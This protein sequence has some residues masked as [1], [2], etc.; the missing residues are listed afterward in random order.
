MLTEPKLVHREKL[1]FVAIQAKVRREDIPV[2]LPQ[3]IPEIINW[4]VDN[5]ILSYGRPFFEYLQIENNQLLVNVGVLL[6]NEIKGNQRII[7]GYFETGT[8]AII[9]YIGN[10]SHLFN[11]HIA[12]E[13]WI[14]KNNLQ[15]KKEILTNGLKWGSRTEFY[16]TD[17]QKELNPDN[18]VTD[19]VFLLND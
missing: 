9:T 15:E 4:L 3:L 11:A 7:G 8:Y 10:Y 18:W 5:N 17:P 1:H 16:I 2:T 13:S 6:Q 19:V 12:L 14:E